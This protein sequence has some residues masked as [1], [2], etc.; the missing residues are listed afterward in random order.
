M[1]KVR[2]VS[3]WLPDAF[4]VL[5][6]IKNFPTEAQGE[7]PNKV[8]A[9]YRDLSL[10]SRTQVNKPG[11]AVQLESLCWGVGKKSVLGVY[12]PTSQDI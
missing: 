5:G 7:R 2:V 3:L 1:S 4:I 11:V 9:L 12:L 6:H 8:F 10:S